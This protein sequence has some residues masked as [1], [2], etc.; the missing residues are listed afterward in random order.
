M[1]SRRVVMETEHIIGCSIRQT[2]T[3][4]DAVSMVTRETHELCVSVERTCPVPTHH[5]HVG[6]KLRP[7]QPSIPSG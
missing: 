7:T 2:E 6:Y 5:I 4:E 1:T 3:G